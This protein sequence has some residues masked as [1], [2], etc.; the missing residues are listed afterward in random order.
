[1][2]TRTFHVTGMTCDHCKTA[3]TNEIT[4]IDGVETVSVDLTTGEV[5]VTAAG[6]IDTGAVAAAVDEAGYE[7][8]S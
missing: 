2:T 4:A 7:L 6:E 1:M 5:T 3:V 8:A